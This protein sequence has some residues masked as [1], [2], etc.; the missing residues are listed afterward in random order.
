MARENAINSAVAASALNAS[1]NQRGR[2]SSKMRQIHHPLFAN[3]SY[4]EA[5]DRCATQPE[6]LHNTEY[7][8]EIMIKERA[9][10][11]TIYSI[12]TDCEGKGKGLVKYCSDP[13]PRDLMFSPSHGPFKYVLLSSAPL[14]LLCSALPRPALLC[15]SRQKF[16]SLTFSTF[17]SSSEQLCV[18]LPIF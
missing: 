9:A 2:A 11:L 14:A 13:L 7:K 17:Y 16:S 12:I 6:S 18:I 8:I 3:L 15:F 10:K 5:E 4:K 1:G